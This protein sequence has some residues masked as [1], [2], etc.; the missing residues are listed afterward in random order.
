[1]EVGENINNLESVV[2]GE[3]IT[4]SFNHKYIIDCFQ[5]IDAD[6]VSLSFSDTNKPM[7]IRGVGDKG[8]LY[9]VMPMNK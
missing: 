1:M 6:S 5:S 2:K 4:I 3:A 8:F 7:V 9:L